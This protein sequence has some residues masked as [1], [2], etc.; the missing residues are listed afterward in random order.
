M[1]ASRAR[2]TRNRLPGRRQ[3]RTAN[4]TTIARSGSPRYSPSSAG[5]ACADGPKCCARL[6]ADR[7]VPRRERE[8]DQVG[9]VVRG[10]RDH[11]LVVAEGVVEERGREHGRDA[12][13]AE[14]RQERRARSGAR[15]AG[16]TATPSRSPAARQSVSVKRT[17][18]ENRSC[19]ASSGPEP[20]DEAAG[21]RA[22]PRG[23][24]A[25]RAPRAAR[26]RPRSCAGARAPA[27]T[28]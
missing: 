14:E 28:T 9:R 11:A 10:R 22:R 19:S 24:A 23:T 21:R 6:P 27:P 5:H 13:G 25:R 26:G 18:V 3:R 4:S 15:R 1:T 12:V 17:S 16:T 2:A 8:V 20:D 7:G